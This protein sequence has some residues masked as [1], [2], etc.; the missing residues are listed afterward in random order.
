MTAKVMLLLGQVCCCKVIVIVADKSLFHPCR[1]ST[2]APHNN[3]T[4]MVAAL[5]QKI[6]K[7]VT[8]VTEHNQ[9]FPERSQSCG[10]AIFEIRFIQY[11]KNA[12]ESEY[13]KNSLNKCSLHN[14]I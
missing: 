14:K 13:Q 10:T 2:V 4:K 7:L 6:H 9:S 3:I 12:S 8:S 1:I 11:T 5:E